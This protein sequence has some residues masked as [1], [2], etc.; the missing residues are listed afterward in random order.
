MIGKR[1]RPDDL[2]TG[3]ST[4]PN[5]A[6]HGRGAPC[7]TT[8]L[9]IRRDRDPWQPRLWV[10]GTHGGSGESCVAALDS[11][12]AA[13]GHAYPEPSGSAPVVLTCRS[14]VTGLLTAQ[15]AAIQW[16]SGSLPGLRLLGLVIVADSPDRPPKAVRDLARLVTGGLT[17][18][19]SVPWCETWR[20]GERPPAAAL[21]HRFRR[22]TAELN[23]L[24]DP[25]SPALEGNSRASS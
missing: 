5:V 1:R 19:W 8:L 18:S 16:A 22:L 10:V 2:V 24:C 6:H 15:Q 13:A 14:H 4:G 20:L 12:W 21:P 25:E 23:R 11:T 9:P 17:R 3:R 7:P